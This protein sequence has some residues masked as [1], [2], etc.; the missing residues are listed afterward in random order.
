MLRTLSALLLACALA[1]AVHAQTPAAPKTT[2]EL[3]KAMKAAN[4]T[5][6]EKQTALLLKL[7]ELQKEAAQIRFLS[8][9]G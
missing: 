5:Q 6:L 4:Q 9:R 2:L 3:L 1:F 8:K 7:E